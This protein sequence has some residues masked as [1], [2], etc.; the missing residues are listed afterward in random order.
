MFAATQSTQLRFNSSI[1]NTCVEDAKTW[2][3]N[4]HYFVDATHTLYEIK[5]TTSLFIKKMS[6]KWSFCRERKYTASDKLDLKWP[7]CGLWVQFWPVGWLTYCSWLL[8][9]QSAEISSGSKDCVAHGVENTCH[10]IFYLTINLE[11]PIIALINIMVIMWVGVNAPATVS[12]LCIILPE[13][14]LIMLKTFHDQVPSPCILT[15]TIQSDPVQNILNKPLT[16]MFEC[17]C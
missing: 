15:L 10:Y 13:T 9:V 7:N 12:G 2:E 4:C 8:L 5:G 11:L 14:P 17:C 1:T 3:L 6:V 16:R